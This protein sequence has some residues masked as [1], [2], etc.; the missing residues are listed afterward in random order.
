LNLLNAKI[1]L[2]QSEINAKNAELQVLALA[3]RI[4]R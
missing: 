2:S 3:G 1:Q 4:G